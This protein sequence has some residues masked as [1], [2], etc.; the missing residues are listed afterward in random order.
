[1]KKIIFVSMLGIILCV[2]VLSAKSLF[3]YLDETGD[4]DHFLLNASKDTVWVTFSVPEDAEFAV[5][6]LG[7]TGANLGYFE[8]NED[9]GYDIKLTGGGKFTLVIICRSGEGKWTASW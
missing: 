2:G 1:M 8:L 9:E 4:A 5:V 7:S 6:V 3:G